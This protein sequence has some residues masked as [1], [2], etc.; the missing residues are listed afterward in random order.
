MKSQF[1]NVKDVTTDCDVDHG[2]CVGILVKETAKD[3][4]WIYI[5]VK[6]E[7]DAINLASLIL[8]NNTK[9]IQLVSDIQ[10]ES[11]HES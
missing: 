7:G 10:A 9:R 8:T 4:G 3:M 1:Y 5:Y 6:T 2:P 11:K